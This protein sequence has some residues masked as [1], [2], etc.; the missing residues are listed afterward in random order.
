M[1]TL[2]SLLSTLA[3]IVA[4]SSLDSH[5]LDAD[6]LFPALAVAAVFAFALTEGRGPAR[7]ALVEHFSRFP[8][9]VAHFESR[10]QQPLKMAA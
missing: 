3:L 6:V 7:P 9:P 5:R 10:R 4:V 1:K 2:I 8:R